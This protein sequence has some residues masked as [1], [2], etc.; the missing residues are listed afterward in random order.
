[1]RIW[2]ELV[3]SWST[4][5]LGITYICDNRYVDTDHFWNSN[6]SLKEAV[7]DACRDLR[8]W[9]KVF[10]GYTTNDLLRKLITAEIP[11]VM[12]SKHWD[13][14][15]IIEVEEYKKTGKYRDHPEI[16]IFIQ[17]EYERVRTEML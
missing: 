8:R 9:F 1:M 6:T 7:K 13:V 10:I 11:E 16:Q 4:Y 15:K 2:F 12:W 17:E 3:K 5:C 14:S